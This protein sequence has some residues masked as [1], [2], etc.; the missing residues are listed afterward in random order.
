M[1]TILLV[2]IISCSKSQDVEPMNS[3]SQ[4]LQY[5][6]LSASNNIYPFW[7][8]TFQYLGSNQWYDYK[9]GDTLIVRRR[10]EVTDDSGDEI[11][12]RFLIKANEWIIPLN[13]KRIRFDATF[14]VDDLGNQILNPNNGL[15][16]DKQIVNF[17]LQQYSENQ[18]L[19]CEIETLNGSYGLNSTLIDKMWIKLDD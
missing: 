4:N 12:Y 16:F 15:K 8:D 14:Y 9:V 19:A 7:P 3:N 6:G 11:E 5:I 1:F 17:R 18:V 13:V 2:I 10:D